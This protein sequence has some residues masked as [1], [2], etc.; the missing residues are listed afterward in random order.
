MVPIR[1]IVLSMRPFKVEV[2]VKDKVEVKVK[3]DP[4]PWSGP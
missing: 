1:R 3:K 4:Y 2:K